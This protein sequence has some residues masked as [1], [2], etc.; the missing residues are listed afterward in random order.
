LGYFVKKHINPV[1]KDISV[2]ICFIRTEWDKFQ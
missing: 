1:D 2:N